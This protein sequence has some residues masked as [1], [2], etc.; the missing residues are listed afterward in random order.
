MRK[1]IIFALIFIIPILAFGQQQDWYVQVGVFERPVERSYFNNL[2]YEVSYGS[3]AYGLHRYYSA[4]GT[5]AKANE[6]MAAAREK[7][8]NPV[9]L[10]KDMLRGS[11]C[12]APSYTTPT[13][14]LSSIQNIFFDFDK[15]NL[16]SIS[17]KQ[18]NDLGSI[19]RANPGYTAKLRA[20]TD[21]KGSF[22]YNEA[23]STRR[24]RTA[25]KFLQ[26]MGTPSSQIQTETFG[27]N[28]PIAKNELSNGSDTEEGRQFNRRVEIVIMDAQ[29]NILNNMVD[30]IYVPESLSKE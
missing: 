29:G 30:K 27:E 23:L 6:C 20:H 12:S 7:G 1:Q 25:Q 17:K 24:A 3:G 5:E 2:G 21:A 28:D 26:Q 22:V 9:L 13:V 19:L 15:S 14:E 8:Y 10:T 18:L 4:C 16:R 11:C